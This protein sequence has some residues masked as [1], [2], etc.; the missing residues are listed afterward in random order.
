MKYAIL[1][2][3]FAMMLCAQVTPEQFNTAMG[4]N[5]FGDGDLWNE[6]APSLAARLKCRLAG[7]G[8]EGVVHYSAYVN[9]LPCFGSKV[10]Q[11]R[12]NERDGKLVQVALILGNKGDSVKGTKES[13]VK[14]A[15]TKEAKALRKSINDVLG[16][17][18]KGDLSLSGKNI[19]VDWWQCGESAVVLDAESGEFIILRFMSVATF[20]AGVSRKEARQKV[21]AANL[22]KNIDRKDNGDVY[23]M[24]V[25]MVDQGP[26]GYCAPAS[27]ERVFLYLGIQ[28]V[29]MHRIADEAKTGVG[30]GTSSEELEKIAQKWGRRYGVSTHT[31]PFKFRSIQKAIDEG[32]PMIWTMWSTNVYGERA[33]QNTHARQTMTTEQWLKTLK[34][35]KKIK[36]VHEGPHICLVIGYNATTNEIAVSNSWG[37][38]AAALW[39]VRMEDAEVVARGKLVYLKP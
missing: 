7:D 35:Q 3:F 39:W 4:L 28:G 38:S 34:K 24:N 14:N 22:V 33:N 37:Q 20:E 31:A 6:S 18:Q 30:G 27:L 26:K 13:A 32:L 23:L 29:D 19:R 16:K 36:N 5:L 1:P 10:T 8:G 11:I 9:K 17:S 2:L 12:A 21:Q 25:P 15:L